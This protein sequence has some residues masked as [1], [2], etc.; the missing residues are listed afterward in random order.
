VLE[1]RITLHHDCY[2]SS[3]RKNSFHDLTL[4]R[5]KNTSWMDDLKE[6]ADQIE[7]DK[8]LE[9]KKL[10]NARI[11]LVKKNIEL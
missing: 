8:G 2:G 11:A 9:W 4:E 5:F 3:W 7:K 1:D 10:R 6:Y